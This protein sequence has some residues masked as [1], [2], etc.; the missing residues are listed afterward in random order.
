MRILIAEDESVSR[1]ALQRAVGRWGY[2]GIAVDRGTLAW[3]LLRQPDGPRLALLD[4]EIPEITGPE[5]CLKLR[6]LAPEQPH[7][8][9]LLTARDHPDDIA[10]GLKSGANDYLTK[11]FQPV[12]LEARLSVARRTLE[13][14][15]HLADR[16]RELEQALAQVKQLRGMLPICAW[17]KKVRDDQ[18]YWLQVEEYLS[19]HT[20]VIFSHG[21]CPACMARELGLASKSNHP[22]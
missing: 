15:S 18:N 11:P 21:I 10:A 13:L 5:L 2:E 6:Q 20:E 19:Q 4:W 22:A 7:Y 17:C 8:L 16:V 14:Q 9:I 3:E 1:L 12:E